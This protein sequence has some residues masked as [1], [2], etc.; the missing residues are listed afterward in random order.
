MHVIFVSECEKRALRR[1]RA[2]LDSYAVRIGRRTWVAPMTME[3]LA[4]LHTVL[5]R[6]ATRQTAVACYQNEAARGMRLVWIVGARG[7]FAADGRVPRGRIPAAVGRGRYAALAA[8]RVPAGPG[9][10]SGARLGQGHPPFSAQAAHLAAAARLRAPRVAF[11]LSA[12]RSGSGAG[13]ER[14]LAESC[15]RR[16]IC[17]AQR[18]QGVKSKPGAGQCPGGPGISCGQ[19]PPPVRGRLRAGTV[20]LPCGPS[21]R[22]RFPCADRRGASAGV[23]AAPCRRAGCLAGAASRAAGQAAG[24]GRRTRGRGPYA[25]LVGL[26]DAGQARFDF[27]GPHSLRSGLPHA[28]GSRRLRRQYVF[29]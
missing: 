23:H 1:T 18:L 13:L 26:P 14:G 5:R 7:R 19:S 10:W 22:Q 12:P 20:F 2:V 11:R 15:R 16:L 25:L 9:R 17:I 29:C 4:E 27:C 3:G 8:L 21:F 28:A 6:A 24:Y